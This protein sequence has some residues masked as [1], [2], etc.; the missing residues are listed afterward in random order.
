MKFSLLLLIK[1]FF[2][3]ITDPR[4]FYK[5]VSIS[6]ADG[7]FEINLDKN[8]LK[9]PLGTLFRV[10]TEPLA[11]VVATEWDSQKEMI[12]KHSMHLVRF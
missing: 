10:P 8:K 6:K 1:S 5:N 9:T 3:S 4:K 11:V 2:Q 12:K 7:L